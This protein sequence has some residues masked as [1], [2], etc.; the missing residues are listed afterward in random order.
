MP[1]QARGLFDEGVSSGKAG[2]VTFWQLPSSRLKS[3]TVCEG[4]LGVELNTRL[5]LSSARHGDGSLWRAV[6]F[7]LLLTTPPPRPPRMLLRFKQLARALSRK[8]WRQNLVHSMVKAS[9]VGPARSSCA[10]RTARSTSFGALLLSVV[11]RQL[12]VALFCLPLK[13]WSVPL[14]ASVRCF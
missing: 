14:L 2:L 4:I 5:F 6:M 8:H 1:P 9:H 3:T 13:S 7:A 10:S 12:V 11:V